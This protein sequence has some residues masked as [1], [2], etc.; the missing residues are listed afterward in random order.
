MLSWVWQ[1]S[2]FWPSVPP[3]HFSANGVSSSASITASWLNFRCV[4]R[5]GA[6]YVWTPPAEEVLDLQDRSD[7]QGM[8]ITEMEIRHAVL[9]HRLKKRSYFYFRETRVPETVPSDVY[10][11]F[12]D[13]EDQIRLE[14]LKDQIKEKAGRPVRGYDCRWMGTGF[15]QLGGFGGIQLFIAIQRSAEKGWRVAGSD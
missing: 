12:V 1:P 2:L 6:R 11:E 7:F 4:W 3:S 10:T 9:T 15:D 13:V 8:S 5:L 14:Q